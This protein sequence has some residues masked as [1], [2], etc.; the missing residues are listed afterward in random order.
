MKRLILI[1]CVFLISVSVSA[2]YYDKELRS[3][4]FDT[5]STSYPVHYVK[6]VGVQIKQWLHRL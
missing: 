6:D 5:V 2:L 4:V 3:N 1:L